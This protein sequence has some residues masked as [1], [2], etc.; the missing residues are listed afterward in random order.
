MGCHDELIVAVD[1]TV[2][3]DDKVWL[4]GSSSLLAA[5]VFSNVA[6]AAS[7]AMLAMRD[8]TCFN[9]TC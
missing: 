7:A 8:T 1:V 5:I 2:F 6:A 9:C 3:D 4:I